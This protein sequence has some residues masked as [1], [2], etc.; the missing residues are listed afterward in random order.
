[1]RGQKDQTHAHGKGANKQRADEKAF[2]EG[3]SLIFSFC[4]HA[5]GQLLPD[6]RARFNAPTPSPKPQLFSST[7]KGH[8]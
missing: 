4:G 6:R 3:C 7:T 2:P 8:E 1:M 5:E